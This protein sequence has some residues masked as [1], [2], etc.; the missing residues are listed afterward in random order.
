MTVLQQL[1]WSHYREL[2]KLKNINE[3]EYYIK[4]SIEQN[5]SYRELRNKIK[6]NEYGRLDS[7]TKEKLIT[8]EENKIEDFIKNPI[9]IKNKALLLIFV[10]LLFYIFSEFFS[11]KA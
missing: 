7:K 10:V 9:I 6:L 1:T 5:L 4:L 2:L 11:K 8:Q 3:I